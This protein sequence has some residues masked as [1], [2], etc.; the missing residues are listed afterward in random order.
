MFRGLTLRQILEPVV[1][2]FGGA[3]LVESGRIMSSNVTRGRME[4]VVSFFDQALLAVVDVKLSSVLLESQGQLF[5][6]CFS[7]ITVM[8]LVVS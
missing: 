7:M 5:A 1:G 2:C 8:H 6:E 3:C 4:F